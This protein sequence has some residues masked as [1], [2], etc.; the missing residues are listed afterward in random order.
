MKKENKTNNRSTINLIVK[1]MLDYYL[2]VRN[3]FRRKEYI[4]QHYK[5]YFSPKRDTR[6]VPLLT[7]SGIWLTEAGFQIGDN[8]T[9][10]VKKEHLIIRKNKNQPNRSK[11]NKN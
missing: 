11:S 7:L 10:T 3:T 5:Y 2:I 4:R 6:I 9:I 8:L 1:R